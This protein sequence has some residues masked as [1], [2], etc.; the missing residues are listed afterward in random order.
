M[1]RKREPLW[2]DSR[3]AHSSSS[4]D[5]HATEPSTLATV[6]ITCR[7]AAESALIPKKAN[8]ASRTQARSCFPDGLY[9]ASARTA[10]EATSLLSNM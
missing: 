10:G 4:D 5:R 2:P 8:I 9:S 1:R 3:Q 6:N 7:A